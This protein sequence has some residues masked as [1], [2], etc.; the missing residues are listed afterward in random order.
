MKKLISLIL[1]FSISAQASC[2]WKTG[3][4]SGP[5]KTFIYNEECHQEVGKLVQANKDLTQAIALRDLAIQNSDARIALWEK[6]SNDEFDRLNK[7]E[8]DQKR[9]DW[10]MFGLG[11]ATTFAAAYAA[12]QFTR[13]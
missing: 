9:S 6:S 10:V 12:S 3:I 2:D 5:N 13:R 7:M 11:V 8:N 1:L 4:T